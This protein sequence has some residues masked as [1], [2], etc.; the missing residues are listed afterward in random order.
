MAQITHLSDL[1]P[2]SLER[3]WLTAPHPTLPIVATCSSDKTVRVYSLTNFTLLSAITGGHKRSVR[4]AA[5][6]PHITGESVLATGSF[7]ATVG[8]WRRWDSYGREDGS[9][10]KAA[11]TTNHDDDKSDG[12]AEEDEEEWRFAVLLD[13]HDSEVKSVSWSPSGMLL[14]TCS[15]DKSIWIWEDLDDGDNNFETVAVM[16]EHGGDVKCVAWHPVE[17]CL[18]SGSYDDTIRLWRED[19]DDW[20][21]VA[22]IKGHSGT[23]WFLDWEGAEN[24]PSSSSAHVDTALAS[25]WRTQTALSG[26]RLLSCSDDRSV[27]VWRRQPKESQMAS[28]SSSAVTGIPSIIRP[29]GTDEMWEED[30]VLPHAHELAVYAVAWSKRSGLVAS[31]GADGRIALY[32]ERFVAEN[33][34]PDAMDIG[35]GEGVLKTEWVL[36]AVHDGAH[37]IYEINH[38]AWA[39]RADRGSESGEEVLVTTAD[40]GSVKIWTVQR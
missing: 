10:L 38:C 37:G 15:R 33:Q 23:V 24:V 12:N 36:I 21:Q 39:K 19:L 16:Q 13:G 22:C 26:P 27:R 17:E 34:D 32:E 6:K 35:S 8:I 31:T 2:P 29:T 18:A 28:Q 25:Q 3:T 30:A 20:G 7:D 11:G 9:G 1:T 40:D 5:W 4:T 14:A